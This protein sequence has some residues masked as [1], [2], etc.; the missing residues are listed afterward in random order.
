[1]SV[2]VSLLLLLL[3]LGVLS[4]AAAEDPLPPAGQVS[5]SSL[6][7]GVDDRTFEPEGEQDITLSRP[8]GDNTESPIGDT[9]VDEATEKEEVGVEMPPNEPS[10]E[11]DGVANTEPAAATTRRRSSPDDEWMIRFDKISTDG[12]NPVL[13]PVK[14]TSWTCPIRKEPVR[15]EEKDV[16]NPAAIVKDDRVYLLYRAEDTVLLY[17]TIA[18]LYSLFLIPYCVGILYV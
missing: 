11:Q 12:I 13:E 2:S 8:E 17:S 3:L 1:M 16:F 14:E 4:F 9:T 7:G 10:R 5:D 6:R 15:W 18:V